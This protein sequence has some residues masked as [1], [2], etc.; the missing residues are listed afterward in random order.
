MHKSRESLDEQQKDEIMSNHYY[1][2]TIICPYCDR[3]QKEIDVSDKE[4]G[5]YFEAD[6]EYCT[7]TFEVEVY[8]KDNFS[9][10]E[11]PED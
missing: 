8:G 11:L 3:E 7:D 2:K 6:C 1:T 9:S 4:D 10:I 5:D